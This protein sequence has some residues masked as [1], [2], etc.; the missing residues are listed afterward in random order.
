MK[1]DYCSEKFTIQDSAHGKKQ[2]RGN[3]VDMFR[4]GT[5]SSTAKAF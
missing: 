5:D 2:D 4:L 3:T 1:A